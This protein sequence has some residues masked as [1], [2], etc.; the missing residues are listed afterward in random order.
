VE[1]GTSIHRGPVGEPGARLPGTLRKRGMRVLEMKRLSLSFYGSCARGTRREG[2]FTGYSEGYIKEGS[3]CT[4]PAGEP[5]R[6][7]GL[8]RTLR[9]SERGL[10]KWS[11]SL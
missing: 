1:T 5:G 2:S 8:P 4:D 9:G 3:L 6:M 11:V 10:C 7:P